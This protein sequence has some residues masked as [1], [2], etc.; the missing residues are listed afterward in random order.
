LQNFGDKNRMIQVL[1]V[2]LHFHETE[3][4]LKPGLSL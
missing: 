3:S 2:I 4:H 1:W